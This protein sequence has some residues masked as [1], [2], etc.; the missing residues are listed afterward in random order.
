MLCFMEKRSFEFLKTLASMENCIDCLEADVKDLPSDLVL[1]SLKLTV[2]HLRYWM[3]ELIKD[4]HA[5]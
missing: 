3:D 1:D 2:E 5:E 4:Y